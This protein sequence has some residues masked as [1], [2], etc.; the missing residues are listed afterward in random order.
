MPGPD[1]H[2]VHWRAIP[3]RPPVALVVGDAA[4][5]WI[6]RV[7]GLPEAGGLAWSGPPLVRPGGTGAN[8]AVGLARL[9]VRARL[10]AILAEDD[11]GRLLRDDLRAEGV[12][13]LPDGFAGGLAT[14]VV[15][16]IVDAA[17]ERTLLSCARGSAQTALRASDVPAAA[18]EDAAWLHSTGVLLAEEPSRTA[19]PELLREARRRGLPASLD[20]NIRLD[21]GDAD[22][23]PMP[24]LRRAV[25]EA[26]VV[27]A[28]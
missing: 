11:G 3:S 7:R 27:F 19:L 9:G 8:V 5:D 12:E 25:E 20:L 23:G 24:A 13:V 18:W 22:D 1:G 2:A 26:S 15:I 14:P 4:V 21:R 17:A 28:S 6:V 10:A 16:A